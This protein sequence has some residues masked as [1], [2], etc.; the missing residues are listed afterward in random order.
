MRLEFLPSK[1]IENPTKRD[2]T[3]FLRKIY[4][5]DGDALILFADEEKNQF[6][7]VPKLGSHVEYMQDGVLFTA[8]DVSLDECIKVFLDYLTN[9]RLWRTMLPWM[10]KS[11]EKDDS[12]SHP[13]IVEV[14]KS[15]TRKWEPKKVILSILAG[16]GAVILFCILSTSFPMEKMIFP[17]FMLVLGAIPWL[18]LRTQSR[19]RFTLIEPGK[20][21]LFL[22]I[23]VVLTM[24]FLYITVSQIGLISLSTISVI[25]VSGWAIY[26]SIKLFRQASDFRETCIEIQSDRNWISMMESMDPDAPAFPVLNYVYLNKYHDYK[27]VRWQSRKIGRA[28]R[29]KR[30]VVRIQYLPTDPRIHR[31][32]RIHTK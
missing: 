25:L 19:E 28:I 3:I 9:D 22:I 7:Q 1:S 4:E 11:K 24:G 10:D 30:L 32:S 21:V 12:G 8:D 13:K 5:G 18:I 16:L 23:A 20:A 2:I 14:R 17:G 26:T 29:E 6:I 31:V 27:S 15:I